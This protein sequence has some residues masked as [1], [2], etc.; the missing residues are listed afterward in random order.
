M[1][2]DPCWID[3]LQ[4]QHKKPCPMG[5][6][7]L[8]PT[9]SLPPCPGEGGCLSLAWS[10][11]SSPAPAQSPNPPT[12]LQP[13][14]DYR[15]VMQLFL[16]DTYP[17]KSW[18]SNFAPL[19]PILLQAGLSLLIHDGTVNLAKK[20]FQNHAPSKNWTLRFLRKSVIFSFLH[21]PLGENIMSK[22]LS[23]ELLSRC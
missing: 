16:S 23:V 7:E 5:C 4:S 2:L 17:H 21:L 22:G 12:T 19:N 9:V 10:G 3:L 1:E 14:S 18:C 11:S 15:S 13:T 6:A 8:C 20:T